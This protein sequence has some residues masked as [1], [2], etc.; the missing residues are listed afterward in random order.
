MMEFQKPHTTI[1][2]YRS[3]YTQATHLFNEFGDH[4]AKYDSII[5]LNVLARDTDLGVFIQLMFVLV[6]V[7]CGRTDVK[8]NDLGAAVHKPPSRVYLQKIGYNLMNMTC[9]L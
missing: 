3:Y 4:E 9:R 8:E 1:Y 6:K 2:I 7:D 5:T